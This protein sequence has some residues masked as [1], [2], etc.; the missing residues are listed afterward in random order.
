MSIRFR[1]L[2]S[3][4]VILKLIEIFRRSQSFEKSSRAS[5]KFWSLMC[6]RISL[7]V[8][9]LKVLIWIWAKYFVL[10][11]VLLLPY[12]W[13]CQS[14]YLWLNTFPIDYDSR[15]FFFL[16]FVIGEVWVDLELGRSTKI[17]DITIYFCESISQCQII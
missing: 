5:S 15:L 11:S 1:L 9:I 7:G 8:L 2:T 13:L 3:Y 16:L 12:S 4:V 14:A 17:V 6:S 10:Q